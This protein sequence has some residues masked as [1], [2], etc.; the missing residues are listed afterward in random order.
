[1]ALKHLE[2]RNAINLEMSI[3]FLFNKNCLNMY[4]YWKNKKLETFKN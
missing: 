1:M 3:L 4:R 2:S